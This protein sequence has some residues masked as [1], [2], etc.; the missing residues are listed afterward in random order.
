MR[1]LRIVRVRASRTD[2]VR[3]TVT[4]QECELVDAL[5]CK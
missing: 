2:T 4:K 1:E 3:V 5:A